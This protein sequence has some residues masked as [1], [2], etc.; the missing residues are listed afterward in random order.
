VSDGTGGQRFNRAGETGKDKP[1]RNRL[2]NF[3]LGGE[4]ALPELVGHITKL[5]P[6]GR[7]VKV[8]S[9]VNLEAHS[10]LRLYFVFFV[11]VY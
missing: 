11:V 2:S 1:G 6:S 5:M 10:K 7:Q 9:F 4:I 3:T 8:V